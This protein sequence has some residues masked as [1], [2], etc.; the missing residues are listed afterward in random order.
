MKKISKENEEKKTN[1]YI[2]KERL[3]S[4]DDKNIYVWSYQCG[5]WR[6]ESDYRNKMIDKMNA[7]HEDFEK[8]CYLYSGT[9]AVASCSICKKIFYKT[10]DLDKHNKLKIQC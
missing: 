7:N 4:I 1:I 10:E 8:E 6:F 3:S 9:L 5:N 2:F